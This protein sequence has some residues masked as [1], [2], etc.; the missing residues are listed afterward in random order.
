MLLLRCIKIETYLDRFDA[1]A[2]RWLATMVYRVHGKHACTHARTCRHLLVMLIAPAV[3]HL[4]ELGFGH[5]E[6]KTLGCYLTLLLCLQTYL[7][8]NTSEN[9]GL[10]YQALH[11]SRDTSDLL[12][13]AQKDGTLWRYLCSSIGA[14]GQISTVELLA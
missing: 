11:S 10:P 6:Q 4:F 5:L 13:S 12:C 8:K 1:A 9:S 14:S 2:E 7:S 3:R